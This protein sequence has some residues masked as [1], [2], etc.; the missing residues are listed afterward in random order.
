MDERDRNIEALS[1]QAL[2]DVVVVVAV[3]GVA[4]VVVVAGVAVAVAV[5]TE[6]D[7]EGGS[8][9]EQRRNPPCA[10]HGQRWD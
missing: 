4:V 3:D 10:Q 5:D 8:C 2:V 9:P 6:D 1:R 7:V